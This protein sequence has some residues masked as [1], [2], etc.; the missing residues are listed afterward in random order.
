MSTLESITERVNRNGHPDDPNTPRPLLT[1]EESFQGNH[2]TG[3]I[4]CNLYPC[5]EPHQVHIALQEIEQRDDV[6]AIY[7]Q[8]TAFDDP[9]WPFSDTAWV[10]TTA[11]SDVVA[12]WIP[13]DSSTAD[14]V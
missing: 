11:D 1:L 8:V 2:V 4:C 12:S 9:D 10:I 3:S 7:V 5:P 13:E 14:D 6:S